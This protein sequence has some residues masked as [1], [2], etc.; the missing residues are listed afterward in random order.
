MN[1]RVVSLNFGTLLRI[2]AWLC[3]AGIAF[4]TL[5]PIGLRPTTG[6]SPSIERFVA[7][8]VVGALFGAA[9]P[10]YILFAAM[11]VLGAAVLFELLQVLEASRHGRL[12]DASVKLAGGAIGLAAGSIAG[13]LLRSD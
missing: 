8:A 10:R 3:L 2:A 9:Y 5:S 4:A 11:I 1:S 7:F 6:F 13:R 12:F